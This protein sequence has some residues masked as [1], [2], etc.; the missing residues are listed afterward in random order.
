LFIG[1]ERAFI[2]VTAELR[3]LHLADASAFLKTSYD[4]ASRLTWHPTLVAFVTAALAAMVTSWYVLHR[5]TEDYRYGLRSK[6]AHVWVAI[7]AVVIFL[8]TWFIYPVFFV[9]IG[10]LHP[11][12]ESALAGC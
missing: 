5:S 1:N 2:D 3:I 4:I 6:K 7:G 9:R 10:V 11:L 12:V 8:G